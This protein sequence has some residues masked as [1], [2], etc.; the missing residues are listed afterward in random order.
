MDPKVVRD[1]VFQALLAKHELAGRKLRDAVIAMRAWYL[2]HHKRP[3][4]ENTSEKWRGALLSED[5]AQR[6]QDVVDAAA[7]LLRYAFEIAPH[8]NCD[9]H[10]EEIY[11]LKLA[12]RERLD[13]QM[14]YGERRPHPK[15]IE[16]RVEIDG[17]PPLTLVIDPKH[18]EYTDR[19]R[20]IRERKKPAM[21]HTQPGDE[22]PS[23]EVDSA[24]E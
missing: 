5:A 4:D 6:H 7:Q 20:R 13:K 17:G 24:P 16:E 14:G 18:W 19:A 12:H 22:S 15:G 2:D 3:L 11:K 8:S 23:S 10:L 21:P 9:L 1:P